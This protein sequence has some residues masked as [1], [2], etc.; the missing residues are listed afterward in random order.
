MKSKLCIVACVQDIPSIE[1]FQSSHTSPHQNRKGATRPAPLV[2]TVPTPVP[3]PDGPPD[4]LVPVGAGVVSTPGPGVVRLPFPVPSRGVPEK[5][6]CQR[7]H[8]PSSPPSW[9]DDLHDSVTTLVMVPHPR[10]S[11]PSSHG[12][13]AKMV[14]GGLGQ[15]QLTVIVS[16]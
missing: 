15:P 8:P 16:S 3:V 12:W 14:T 13:L 11:Q 7:Q 1:T 2:M 5:K 4:P 6:K 9:A 10:L